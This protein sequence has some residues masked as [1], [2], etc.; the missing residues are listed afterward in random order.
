M[1]YFKL[2]N[3]SFLKKKKKKKKLVL[4]YYQE[5]AKRVETVLTHHSAFSLLLISHMTAV[6]LS[7]L[8]N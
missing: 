4:K 2:R 6:H 3:T 1:I 5:V 7:K 8:R